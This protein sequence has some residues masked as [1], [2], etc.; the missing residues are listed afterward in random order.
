MTWRE[1]GLGHYWPNAAEECQ[2][3]RTGQDIPD[4]FDLH[5]LRDDGSIRLGWGRLLSTLRAGTGS[6][7]QRAE[8][9]C[10]IS[11]GCPFPVK[12]DFC[13]DNINGHMELFLCDSCHQGYHYECVL[14]MGSEDKWDGMLDAKE[15]WRCRAC[16]TKKNFAVSSLLDSLADDKAEE[17]LLIRWYRPTGTLEGE[18]QGNCDG[19]HGHGRCKA[20]HCLAMRDITIS[21]K[22]DIGCD[23]VCLLAATM[24][25]CARICTSSS[26]LGLREGRIG[27]GA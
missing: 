5:A 21:S 12:E 26:R 7:C 6:Q 19:T 27:T 4:C 10:V 18:Q 11:E 15:V 22:A 25:G 13:E 24:Q 17:K 16:I 20:L 3:S 1:V 9:L 23:F 2:N 8:A 14:Q